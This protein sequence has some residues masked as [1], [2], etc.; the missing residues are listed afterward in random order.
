M[1]QH[2]KEAHIKIRKATDER[3]ILRQSIKQAFDQS[4][5]YSEAM[6]ELNKARQKVARVKAAIMEDF[7]REA[8]EI[9]R[10]TLDIR[11]SEVVLAD[12]ALTEL[13][14]GETVEI[15]YEGDDITF[16]PDY[17]VKF[18]KRV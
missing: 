18:K 14:K 17:R 5:P 7:K 12:I 15:K 11:D 1:S 4:K 6:E 9:E 10:K 16:I 2:L 3:K 13:M 8:Q